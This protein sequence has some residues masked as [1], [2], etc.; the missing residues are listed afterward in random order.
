MVGD[1][2][3]HRVGKRLKDAGGIADK[4]DVALY[5]LVYLRRVEVDMDYLRVGCEALAAY[6][7]KGSW[8]SR[9]DEIKSVIARHLEHHP[10]QYWL[11]RLIPAD[12]WCA[13]VLSWQDLINEDAF[14]AL[15][16]VQEVVRD[17]GAGL[18]TTRCPIRIDK[19]KL[20]ARR[21]APKPGEHTDAID[22]EFGLKD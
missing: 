7:D 1:L 20:Y 17:N 21:G 18:R 5:R 19:E 15:G 22:R 6:T 14:K 11:D 12:Y 13:A 9:R 4:V 16:F 2:F 3:L 10:T 8:F